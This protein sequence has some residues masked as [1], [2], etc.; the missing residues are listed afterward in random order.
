MVLKGVL[1][2]EGRFGSYMASPT[3][4]PGL[5]GT[6]QGPWWSSGR[7]VNQK[8]NSGENGDRSSCE[9]QYP[10]E[11]GVSPGRGG[12]EVRGGS[13]SSGHAAGSGAQGLPGGG[14]YSEPEPLPAPPSPR[15][16]RNWA[17][18]VGTTLAKRRAAG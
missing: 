18:W 5:D 9:P 13:A 10:W 4:K 17:L 12:I 16:S 11:A 15:L 1:V 14:A 8:S 3:W 7:G 6:E 2:M